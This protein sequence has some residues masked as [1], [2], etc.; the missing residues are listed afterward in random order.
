MARVGVPV[1]RQILAA[2]VVQHVRID[3]EGERRRCRRLL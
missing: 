2:S 1:V 3:G